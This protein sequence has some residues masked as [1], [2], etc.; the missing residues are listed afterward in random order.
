M[1]SLAEEVTNLKHIQGLLE[2]IIDSSQDA[3]SL[4]MRM[5]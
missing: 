1:L 2:A 5:A 3:I 4:S